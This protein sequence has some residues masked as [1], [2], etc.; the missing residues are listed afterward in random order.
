MTKETAVPEKGVG[1]MQS[2]AVDEIVGI[3]VDS[4][5]FESM[6]MKNAGCRLVQACV[7]Y[8][9]KKFELSYSFTND[10]TY[11]MTTLR[12]ILDDLATEVPSISEI[13]PY[14]SFYENEMHELFDVNIRMI[15]LDYHDRL[16]RI[17]QEAPMIP[18][19][20]REAIHAELD[21]KENA[22]ETA[23]AAD[24]TAAE[25]AAPSDGKGGNE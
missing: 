1:I 18:E 7:A 17:R 21:A 4:L 15:G 12:I 19:D 25:E 24:E 6:K 8:A 16:Y 9:D 22:K 23:A 11:K 14:A 2:G 13:F 5:L 20:A 3:P 10:E